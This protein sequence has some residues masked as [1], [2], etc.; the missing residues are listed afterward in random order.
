MLSSSFLSSRWITTSPR[1]WRKRPIEARSLHT[2]SSRRRSPPQARG[3]AS[4]CQPP[5][6]RQ[7]Q[8]LGRAGS[9]PPHPS[10]PRCSCVARV[11]QVRRDDAHTDTPRRVFRFTRVVLRRLSLSIFLL[12]LPFLFPTTLVSRF[13]F[14]PFRPLLYSAP[15]PHAPNL[16]TGTPRTATPTTDPYPSRR[17][18]THPPSLLYSFFF[19]SFQSSRVASFAD[20]AFLLV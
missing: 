5:P 16:P 2:S 3:G 19:L 4:A 7:R 10:A 13:F 6:R 18:S 9:T 11:N 20:R 8:H 15:L 17:Q 12:F 1:G 14:F